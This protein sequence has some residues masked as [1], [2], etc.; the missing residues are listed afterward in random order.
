MDDANHYIGKFDAQ[1]EHKLNS[2]V[3]EVGQEFTLVYLPAKE[4]ATEAMWVIDPSESGK[5]ITI[6]VTCGEDTG[7]DDDKEPHSSPYD[8]LKDLIKV[9]V[10]C[11]NTDVS[12]ADK[13]YGLLKGSYDVELDEADNTWNVTVRSGDYIVK[14]EKENSNVPHG[15]TSDTDTGSETV[16]V[17][18]EGDGWKLA[19][20][21]A[22]TT[23]TFKVKCG[24]T[25]IKVPGEAKTTGT[26]CTW[27]PKTPP[28]LTRPAWPTCWRLTTT[29]STCSAIP[30]AALGPIAT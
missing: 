16:S 14:Y 27:T 21:N 17:V 4:D 18:K 7:D 2:I 1:N 24:S 26:L 8:Q 22:P 25:I 5:F 9:T 11:T 13:P 15:L 19:N 10:D 6:N 29:F 28:I 3:P 12:H 30:T 20:G 23:I